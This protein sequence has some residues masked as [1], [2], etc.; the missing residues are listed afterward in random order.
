[1][2]LLGLPMTKSAVD[3]VSRSV[4]VPLTERESA[5]PFSGHRAE[6][7]PPTQVCPT[8]LGEDNPKNH[9]ESAATVGHRPPWIPE[10]PPISCW[11]VLEKPEG[12][13]GL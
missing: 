6:V 7:C 4:L 9:L 10:R 3:L 11:S 1:M 2:Q 12:H 13:L 5:Q 8:F